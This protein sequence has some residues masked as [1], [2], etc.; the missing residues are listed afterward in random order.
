MHWSSLDSVLLS[1]LQRKYGGER[2]RWKINHIYI[3]LCGWVKKKNDIVHCCPDDTHPRAWLHS[4]YSM[5]PLSMCRAKVKAM[6]KCSSAPLTFEFRGR[7]EQSMITSKLGEEQTKPID[8]FDKHRGE[9]EHSNC[10][11][12]SR[13]SVTAN[14]Q[15]ATWNQKQ[16]NIWAE[17]HI[18]FWH[19][20]TKCGSVCVVHLF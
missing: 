2:G 12:A 5:Q 16:Y 6:Q 19:F 20:G 7:E 10:Q 3:I 1:A 18:N 17:S 11:H 14:I 4:F 8:W 13:T 9:R 15:A